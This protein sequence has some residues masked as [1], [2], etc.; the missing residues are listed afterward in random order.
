MDHR[1]LQIL[2]NLGGGLLALGPLVPGDQD[3]HARAQIVGALELLFESQT[4]LAAV[5]GDV[6]AVALAALGTAG[7]GTGDA[8]HAA[9]RDRVGLQASFLPAPPAVAG[10]LIL[11]VAQLALLAHV[12]GDPAD[13]EAVVLPSGTGTVLVGGGAV[14][15]EQRSALILEVHIGVLLHEGGVDL[16][17]LLLVLTVVDVLAARVAGACEDADLGGT[18]DLGPD[19]EEQLGGILDHTE[20]G[21]GITHGSGIVGGVVGPIHEDEVHACV[22]E[23]LGVLGDHVAVIGEVVPVQGSVPGVLAPGDDLGAEPGGVGDAH[24]TVLVGS[25]LVDTHTDLVDLHVIVV[26]DDVLVEL[27]ALGQSLLALVGEGGGRGGHVDRGVGGSDGITHPAGQVV[28]GDE[29]AAAAGEG[30]GAGVGFAVKIHLGG[31]HLVGQGS[32]VTG[33][34]SGGA[35][36]GD[37]ALVAEEGSGGL[38]IH[39]G[40]TVVEGDGVSR[41]DLGLVA[42]QEVIAVLQLGADIVGRVGNDGARLQAHGLGGGVGE[43][44]HGA[45]EAQG[46]AVGD[47]RQVGGTA[48]LVALGI[49]DGE[50]IPLHHGLGD[51]G[52]VDVALDGGAVVLDGDVQAV[53]GIKAEVVAD[54][55]GKAVLDVDVD[56]LFREGEPQAAVDVEVIRA[57]DT[58]AHHDGADVVFSAAVDD[59][60]LGGVVTHKG[61]GK[62]HAVPAIVGDGQTVAV[63]RVVLVG[64]E[65]EVVVAFQ[66]AVGVV[67][68][69]VGQVQAIIGAGHEG[70]QTDILVGGNLDLNGRLGLGLGLGG[71]LGGSLGRRIGGRLG[72]GIGIGQSDGGVAFRVGGVA[73]RTGYGGQ[74]HEGGED[75]AKQLFH[76]DVPWLK[77]LERSPCGIVGFS[78]ENLQI[79]HSIQRGICQWKIVCIQE[80]RPA[81]DTGR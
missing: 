5:G 59:G 61:M 73:A 33:Q 71:L 26:V 35:V 67:S 52:T 6:A 38:G 72:G 11:I 62:A 19:L 34:G 12:A 15:H 49:V 42:E 79:Y 48:H 1:G 24:Q 14:A 21:E 81:I 22:A 25:G 37:G 66:L 63:H 41:L 75:A 58:A 16:I 65:D 64:G 40:H 4:V 47:A 46:V 45:D 29:D 27:V 3:D 54:Q 10:G 76:H 74:E 30:G 51:G 77:G 32:P 18:L 9:I 55:G 69:V 2:G 78:V 23:Q 68:E 31:I 56:R 44:G 43:V 80:N 8:L 50:G 7:G 13:G 39:K 20:V 70:S 36:L 28:G 57:G 53:L 60:G 17:H